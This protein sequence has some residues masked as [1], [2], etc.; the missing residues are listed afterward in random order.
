MLGF[1]RENVT[2]ITGIYA[3]KIREEIRRKY[4]GEKTEEDIKNEERSKEIKSLYNAIWK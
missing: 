1:E 4:A 2:V 3:E